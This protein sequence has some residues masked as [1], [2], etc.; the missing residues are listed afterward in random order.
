MGELVVFTADVLDV[1]I[2]VQL[3]EMSE[4]ITFLPT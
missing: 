2:P 3:A 4:E 1:L